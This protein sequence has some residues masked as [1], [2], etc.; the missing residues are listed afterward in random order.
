MSS[1]RIF[2]T[3]SEHGADWTELTCGAEP[4]VRIQARDLQHAQRASRRLHADT[5]AAVV[6]DLEVLI[7][8]DRR[9]ARRLLSAVSPSRET[10]HY[11]GTVDGLAGLLADIE[12]A[13]VADGVTLIPVAPEQDARALAERAL[14]RLRLKQAS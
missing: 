3:G 14:S 9:A 10:V 11:V 1:L 13:G 12:S 6:L 2:I 5:D 4:A 8:E 7:A